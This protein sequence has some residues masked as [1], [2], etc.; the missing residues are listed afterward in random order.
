MRRDRL[1]LQRI[2]DAHYEHQE[3]RNV[4]RSLVNNLS[5][6][7]EVHVA[8]LRT[9]DRDTTRYQERRFVHDRVTGTITGIREASEK[10]F[11]SL[12]PS[13][14]II[15]SRFMFAFEGHQESGRMFASPE[16]QLHDSHIG[17]L[18][19]IRTEVMRLRFSYVRRRCIDPS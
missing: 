15:I 8:H 19:Q 2:F 10:G 18:E 4:L 7:L 1:E 14:K 9:L 11:L 17:M 6:I 13:L 3:Q 5:P 16:G 12:Q